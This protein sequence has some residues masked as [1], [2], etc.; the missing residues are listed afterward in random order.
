MLIG[1][2]VGQHQIKVPQ[3]DASNWSDFCIQRYWAQFEFKDLAAAIRGN[4]NSVFA[5]E[6]LD[7]LRKCIAFRQGRRD[8]RMARGRNLLAEEPGSESENEE[9]G[10]KE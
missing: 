10:E 3:W 8:T 5:Q 7:Q 9:E 2:E 4:N 1:E 6:Y